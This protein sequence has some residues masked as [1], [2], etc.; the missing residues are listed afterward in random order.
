MHQE[1]LLHLRCKK[2]KYDINWYRFFLPK[3]VIWYT[4]FKP[5][6]ITLVDTLTRTCFLPKKLYDANSKVLHR[7]KLF[8]E[9]PWFAPFPQALLAQSTSCEEL[10]CLSYIV[11]G[12]VGGGG[13]EGGVNSKFDYVCASLCDH[14]GWSFEHSHNGFINLSHDY[15]VEYWKIHLGWEKETFNHGWFDNWWNHIH[16]Q[17]FN[18]FK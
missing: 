6:F 12:C 1:N 17:P 13:G 2:Q 16:I 7:M 11:L 8:K 5:K 15:L 14:P 9:K 3:K 10:G 4:T 18:N